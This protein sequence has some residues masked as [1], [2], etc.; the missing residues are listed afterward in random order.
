MIEIDRSG[1]HIPLLPFKVDSSDWCSQKV[2]ESVCF[3]KSI[4]RKMHECHI[5]M[6]VEDYLRVTVIVTNYIESIKL[7]KSYFEFKSADNAIIFV[8]KL[9]HN[10]LKNRF[11]YKIKERPKNI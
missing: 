10:K 11:K 5:F 9:S 2:F 7:R 4:N 8:G 1:L 3:E 6:R